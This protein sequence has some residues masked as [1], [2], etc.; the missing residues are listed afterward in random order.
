MNTLIIKVDFNNE[1]KE[2]VFQRKYKTKKLYRK[3]LSVT[4]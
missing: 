4:N 2:Y 1:L 3:V